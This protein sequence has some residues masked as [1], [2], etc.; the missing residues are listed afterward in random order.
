MN[1]LLALAGDYTIQTVSM[2]AALVGIISGAL[3]TFAVLRQQSLLGDTLAHAALPGVC[4]GFIV[5]GTR[6]IESILAGAMVTGA[7]AAFVML[8]LIKRS[9]LKTDAALGI[10]LSVSF[11][12][13][14]VLL[15][16][17][18]GTNNAAQ[19]GLDSFLFGQAAAILRSDLPIMAGITATALAVLALLWKELKL[20]TFDPEYAA[21]IGLPVAALESLLTAMIVLAVVV[22]LQMVGVVLMA[23]MVIAPA[24]A[25]R[26]WTNRLGGMVVLAS[27][28]GL[29]GGVIGAGVS[30]VER[31]LATG[32]LIILATSVLVLVSLA[33]APGRGL[34][35]TAAKRR[36][37]RQRLARARV[38]LP[39]YD[40]AADRDTLPGGRRR[41][42]GLARAGLVRSDGRRWKLTEAGRDEA[43]RLMTELHLERA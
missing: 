39:L 15:T 19:G 11:A 32:P 38:L 8:L 42:T 34:V 3:G 10:V 37:D 25:A 17:I 5:A 43:R 36:A 18:Q 13:G 1:T 2:G 27:I 4:L 24:V 6:Q 33:F 9:R 40:N 20:V 41:L 22:G 31:G 29:V 23:S 14:V 16:Y 35:W 26:Q 12:V 28:I 30:A 7:L 21:A